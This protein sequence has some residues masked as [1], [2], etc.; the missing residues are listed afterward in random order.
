[1][2]K[3]AIVGVE[4]SGKT[5]LMAALGE[6][7]GQASHDSM[8]LMPENQAAFAFMTRIPHKMRVEHQWP[9]ATAIESMK[10]MKWTV[11]IGADVL[12][13]LEMLDYPGEL[14][15]M[16]FGD[17]K[18]TDI[19]GTKEQ[20]HEFL[21]H[22][23]T[24]DF[25]IVLMNLKDAMDIGASA[26][27][28]E[29]VW[30]TRGIFDYAKKLPN[31]KNRL[32][33]FTQAD[34]YRDLLDG[35]E[36]AKIAQ[37]KYLPMLSIL[38]PDLECIAISAVE[39]SDLDVPGMKPT[40]DGGM[41]ELI[42]RIVSASELG[43]RAIKMIEECSTAAIEAT[44]EYS[45]FGD[46]Q[47]AISNYGE[48]L[49]SVGSAEVGVICGIYPGILDDHSERITLL[50]EFAEDIRKVMAASSASQL[51]ADHTW[52]VLNEKY[53][54]LSAQLAT[55]QNIK[56]G[57]AKGVRKWKS[58]IVVV[59]VLCFVAVV[60]ALG[61]RHYSRELAISQIMIATALPRETVIQ[62]FRE[63]ARAEY[64]VGTNLLAKEISQYRASAVEWLAKASAHGHREAQMALGALYSTLYRSP[65]GIPKD[66]KS[67]ELMKRYADQGA[68]WAKNI[69]GEMYS[70][71]HGVPENKAEALKYY[72]TSAEGGDIYGMLSLGQMYSRGD[73]TSQNYK[74]AAIWL[75]QAATL[76][77]AEAQC[78]LGE[79]YITGDG[80]VKSHAEAMK[81]L[82]LAVDQGHIHAKARLA[83]MYLVRSME[84][85]DKKSSEDDT[86]KAVALY[87]EAAGAGDVDAQIA[88]GGI[89]YTSESNK[90]EAVEWLEK[91]AAQGSTNAMTVL[92]QMYRL[93]EGIPQN[94]QEA[95][96]WYKMAADL[97][98]AS[99][100][101][102]VGMMYYSGSGVAQSVQDAIQW[103]RKS[104]DRGDAD[105]QTTLGFQYSTG[106]G[107]DK[108]DGEAV[109]LWRLAAD[110]NSSVAQY[111]LGKMYEAGR[112]V[113]QDDQEAF[114]WLLKAADQGDAD[115]Q[116][117]VG[118]HYI[119]G[120]GTSEDSALSL[121][122]LEMAGRQGN[123]EAQFR[124]GLNYDQ[125]YGV[126][127]NP[128]AAVGWYKLA[129]EHG[130]LRAQYNLGMCYA[131][132]RG[133]PRD[134][135]VAVKY[136]KMAAD[137]GDG[138]AQDLLGTAYSEGLG[139]PKDDVVAT[140]WYRMA[141]DWGSTHAMLALGYRYSQGLG[142]PKDEEEAASWY[143]IAADKG[144]ASAQYLLG[145]RYEK[146]RGVPQN[147]VEAIKYMRLAADQGDAD[148][149]FE[150]GWRYNN[151]EGV[152]QD[153]SEANKWYRLAANQG[154][155]NAQYNLGVAYANGEGVP[156]N[157]TL[158][159][160]YW[161]QS[162]AQ[163]YASAQYNL[164][165]TYET[166]KGVPR[167]LSEAVK[168]YRLAANQGDVN[169][170]QSLRDLGY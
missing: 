76:G 87:Y 155:A 75:K 132:G 154:H 99:S 65:N 140:K 129:A 118:I 153:I 10:Y 25:L 93:G 57:Y 13:E 51:G 165:L 6:M 77:L 23:V 74:L 106:A 12:T 142:V 43:R 52:K 148:A 34:R 151:G 29:T 33:V 46:L 141:A 44:K 35:T 94:H 63:N 147:E 136:W 64:E 120:K 21:E 39:A 81:W 128:E 160:Q 1:M 161:E 102:F 40:E 8:Y 109:R 103:L 17:R 70:A 32:L 91:A 139:V 47:H 5:V 162:A 4:G 22:L 42:A 84:K 92:G 110:Q 137:Q 133:V 24:A 169:A 152:P 111:Y 83:G 166:G 68:P 55:I 107:V 82:Q 157:R 123:V 28:N 156:K 168:W 143:R 131:R 69:L 159:I 30:L 130:D 66:N 7:Y 3:V 138:G 150:M 14:Y 122:Y 73:G 38:H 36:G 31:I 27:N 41:R 97:G 98:D 60:A 112:G 79:L 113:Q 19:A 58:A 61:V 125:G 124:M 146:G 54:D 115:A 9:E 135:A 56:Q 90:Y 37:E 18:E 144:S 59:G 53:A 20:I 89:L 105:A 164:G 85:K 15:R 26:R 158:A 117:A 72:Q 149:Q 167:N 145:K 100:Q 116:L 80:V 126:T 170:K 101:Y 48:V 16:A 108:D 114:R 88:I 104:A 134:D 95:F 163:G 121:K 45:T 71:G 86:R 119:S 96:K 67:V 49:N 78:Q 2:S 11:R 62:A 50:R 127:K